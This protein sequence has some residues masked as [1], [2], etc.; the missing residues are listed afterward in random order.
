MSLIPSRE[1]YLYTEEKHKAHIESVCCMLD[2]YEGNN[3]RIVKSYDSNNQ[4]I[5]KVQDAS[6]VES[7]YNYE[8]DDL[9]RAISLF[10]QLEPLPER[11]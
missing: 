8:T 2:M 11:P 1:D 5:W 7:V 4:P 10:L 3:W 9:D 6:T